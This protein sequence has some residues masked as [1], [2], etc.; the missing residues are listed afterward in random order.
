MDTGFTVG[1]ADAT[2]D[3]V[4]L[5]VG[6]ADW[7]A[8][9]LTKLLVVVAIANSKVSF[10]VRRYTLWQMV[11]LLWSTYYFYVQFVSAVCA[12]AVQL[13]DVLNL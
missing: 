6:A 12:D 1:A 11:V 4:I 9:K 13:L 3:G 5:D 10:M 2:T 7:A 8:A